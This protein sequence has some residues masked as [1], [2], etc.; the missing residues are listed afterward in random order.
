MD[1]KLPE[2]L[3]RNAPDP[4]ICAGAYKKAKSPKD[5]PRIISFDVETKIDAAG[6]VKTIPAGK[7]FC[8]ARP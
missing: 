6:R 2:P 8:D 1:G 4:M 3:A 7:P 5:N